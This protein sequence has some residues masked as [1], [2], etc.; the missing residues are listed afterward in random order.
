MKR[1][2]FLELLKSFNLKDRI[3]TIDTIAYDVKNADIITSKQGHYI[4]H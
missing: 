4:F 3:I 1:R 2:Q